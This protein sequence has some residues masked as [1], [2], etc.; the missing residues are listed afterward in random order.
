MKC[1]RYDEAQLRFGKG[2]KLS[3]NF[4]VRQDGTCSYFFS[5]EDIYSLASNAGSSSCSGCHVSTAH[6]SNPTG[7]ISSVYD[8][9]I[10]NVLNEET[11]W[12]LEVEEC[13]PILRQY[14]NRKQKCARRRVWMHA[15]L[16]KKLL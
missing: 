2:A 13:Y 1:N 8:G 9:A 11:P 7:S 6:T 12:K 4:Y 10:S 16:V 3:D 5:Q 15:K 14:A